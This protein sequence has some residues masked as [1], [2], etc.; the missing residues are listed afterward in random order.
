MCGRTGRGGGKEVMKE[1]KSMTGGWRDKNEK[2]Q[3]GVL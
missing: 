3:Q 1:G 2:T